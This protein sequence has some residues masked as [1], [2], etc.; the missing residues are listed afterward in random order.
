V[1]GTYLLIP[2]TGL[3]VELMRWASRL[4]AVEDYGVIVVINS[5]FLCL[6]CQ[7]V[8]G[9]VCPVLRLLSINT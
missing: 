5:Y 8:T 2:K 7:V 9:I 4:H 3:L 1:S 6:R